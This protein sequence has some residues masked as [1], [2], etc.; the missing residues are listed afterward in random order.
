MN[1]ISLCTGDNC[2]V[3][4]QCRRF[5]AYQRA[6]NHPNGTEYHWHVKPSYKDQ[7]CEN[8]LQL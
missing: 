5:R 2:P 8:Y 1:D 4:D 6:L 3:K 7:K